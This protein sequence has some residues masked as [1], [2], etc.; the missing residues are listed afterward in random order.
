MNPIIDRSQAEGAIMQ[1]IGWM[2]IEEVIYSKEG[3][4]LTDS[5]STYK[6]PDIY[7]APKRSRPGES[8]SFRRNF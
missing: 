2:T 7:F 3:K 1:G 5:M 4:L 8:E 6:V